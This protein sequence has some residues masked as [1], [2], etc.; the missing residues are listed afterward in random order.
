MSVFTIINPKV[1][2][3]LIGDNHNTPSYICVN[4]CVGVCVCNHRYV[5]IKATGSTKL[6]K[7]RTKLEFE[8]GKTA[9]SYSSPYHTSGSLYKLLYKIKII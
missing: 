4:V 9:S 3:I 2:W 1:A 7:R 6:K 5:H 8:W